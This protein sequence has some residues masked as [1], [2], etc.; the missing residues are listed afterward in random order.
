LIHSFKDLLYTWYAVKSEMQ[1][2]LYSLHC[3]LSAPP[4]IKNQYSQNN[5]ENSLKGSLYLAYSPC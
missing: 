5:T 4:L 2:S 1:Y 3:V